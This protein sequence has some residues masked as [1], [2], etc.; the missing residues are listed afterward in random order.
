VA[1]VALFE[2]IAGGHR[3][4]YVRRFVEALQPYADV[5]LALP[6][7]TLDAV[8]DLGVD[9]ISLGSGRPPYDGWLRGRSI[10]RQEVEQLRHVSSLADQAVHLYAD[11]ALFHLATA[12]RLPGA[13][14]LV[15]YTP[16]AHYEDAYG[17]RL[18]QADRAIALAREWAVRRWRRRPDANAV[19]A[20]DEEAAR[21]WATRSGAPAHWLP[22][23]PILG[24]PAEDR[25]AERDGCVLYGQ[26]AARKGIDLV[27]R[28]LTIERTR[29]R[30]V[31]A[32]SI[33]DGY[34][35]ELERHA[36]VIEAAGGEIEVR[37]WRHSE[38]EGLRALASARC[39]LLP[40]PKHPG[41]SRVLVESCSVGTPVIAHDFGLLGHLVRRHRLGLAVDCTDPNALREAV[42][43]LTEAE[44][45]VSYTEHLARFAA[46]FERER[47]RDALL[48]GLRIAGI[49][50]RL[51]E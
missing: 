29:V 13:I 34:L 12:P 7:A 9:T 6:Q 46:R 50:R 30:V 35:P 20:L 28:A 10:L 19:F 31:L 23:P 15:L 3:P 25:T 37:A 24:L 21:R 22:E 16:R 41:M 27:A 47:F 42:L 1:K 48:G 49:D 14:N 39:A 11:Q 2:W 36:A 45:S 32:G 5:I 18:S 8:G 40:Y 38:L 44:R 43:L 51:R 4:I 17:T 26:L 33:D